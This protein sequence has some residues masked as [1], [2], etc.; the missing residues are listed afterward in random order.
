MTSPCRSL[1]SS[2]RR[3][4]IF[5][6]DGPLI[7]MKA[8]KRAPTP[9]I[10][11]SHKSIRLASHFR[12]GRRVPASATRPCLRSLVFRLRKH[13]LQIIDQRLGGRG[14]GLV[15]ATCAFFAR[16]AEHHGRELVE[17]S[18]H[19][20]TRDLR[21]RL[22]ELGRLGSRLGIERESDVDRTFD[23]L[24]EVLAADLERTA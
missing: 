1:M 5:D 7:A 10:R 18:G 8:R 19:L 6:A 11:S 14:R 16:V 2:M 15:A 13:R 24:L 9:P 21:H 4:T 12:E 3:L 20:A 17:R 22:A 23:R